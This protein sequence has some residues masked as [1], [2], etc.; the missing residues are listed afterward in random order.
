MSQLAL[1]HDAQHLTAARRRSTKVSFAAYF[2]PQSCECLLR[3]WMLATLLTGRAWKFHGPHTP[4]HLCWV[5]KGHHLWS[6]TCICTAANS[7][8]MQAGFQQ[9]RPRARV[10]AAGEVDGTILAVRVWLVGGV[11]P[12]ERGT[13]M[14]SWDE[15]AGI[16][17]NCMS[18]SGTA[19]P[20]D[21]RCSGCLMGYMVV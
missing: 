16:T 3:C 12:R 17:A 19:S 2:L 10:P 1:L 6:L 8:S 14:R 7:V 15:S 21:W 4:Q 5:R 11:L 9:R 18:T 20:L 13:V